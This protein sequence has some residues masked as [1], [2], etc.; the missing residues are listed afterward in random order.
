MILDNKHF[1]F[2]EMDFLWVL[3]DYAEYGKNKVN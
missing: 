1:L 2:D 3:G